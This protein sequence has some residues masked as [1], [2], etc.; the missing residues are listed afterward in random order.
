M[1]FDDKARALLSELGIEPSQHDDGVGWVADLAGVTAALRDAAREER[2]ACARLADE[3][4]RAQLKNAEKF[5]H[6]G[7]ERGESINL[8]S[9]ATANLIAFA[10][11]AR[12]E[13]DDGTGEGGGG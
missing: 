5:A 7:D 8:Q 6:G 3:R 12:T 4:E 13:A 2:E 9:A 11:R 10:I 1:T